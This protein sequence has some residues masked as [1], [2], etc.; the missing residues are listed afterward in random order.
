MAKNF[1]QYTGPGGQVLHGYQRRYKKHQLRKKGF[2]LKRDAEKDLRQAMDDLDALERG[3]IRVKPTTAQEAF[4]IYKRDQD[5][6]GQAKSY[7]YRANNEAIYKILRDFV[8]H[9]GPNRLIR[10]CKEDD[11]RE[12]YQILCFRPELHKNT[13][14]SYMSRVQGMMKAAQERKAD[15]ATWRRPT[16]RVNR[17]TKYERRVV[18]PW[19]YA[20]LVQTL[21]V[22]PKVRSHQLLR[23]TGGRLNEVLRIKLSQFIWTM[24]RLRLDATKTENARDLPL[25]NPIREVVQQRIIDELTDDEYL[26]PRAKTESFDKQIGETV[27]E[28]AS[29]AGLEC[30]Q[31]HGFTLHSLRHTF[32]TDMMDATNKDV[33]LVMSWSGHKSLESFQVYLHASEEGRILGAQRV[34]SV[35]LFLRSF[36]GT[37]GTRGTERPPTT[38][39]K[40]FKR[41]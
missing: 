10:D 34:D 4:E 8:K 27:L 39:V 15:L 26:F 29:K 30:G 41:K 5:I 37:G 24:N 19:E 12:F 18:E 20:T 22:P 33:R 1:Y 6:R 25:W 16:L 40:S 2:L 11:L 28:A 32:I 23:L 3:E 35:A 38:V 36:R 9:F 13:A 17:R 31:A 14:G 21:Q 7:N